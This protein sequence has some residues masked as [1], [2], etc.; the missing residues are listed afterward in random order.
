MPPPS[1]TST[2]RNHG[3][4]ALWVPRFF[5]SGLFQGD[6]QLYK[7]LNGGNESVIGLGAAGNFVRL[8]QQALHQLGYGRFLKSGIDGKFGDQT[9]KAVEQFQQDNQLVIDGIVGSETLGKLDSLVVGR[10]RPIVASLQDSNAAMDDEEGPG[11][12]LIL[13]T[14]WRHGST[15]SGLTKVS[16]DVALAILDNMAKSKEQISFLPEKGAVG[17]CSWFTIEGDPYVGRLEGRTIELSV[18]IDISKNALIFKEADIIERIKAKARSFDAEAA[19]RARH[20][21]PKEQVLTKKQSG[22]IQKLQRELPER[23]V[24]NEIGEAI[25]RHS[26]K[27]GIIEYDGVDRGE[28]SLSKGKPGK[29]IAIADPKQI[30]IKG[31]VGSVIEALQAQGHEV[32]PT[33]KEASKELIRRRNASAKVKAVFKYGGRVLIVVG[34]A[35][36]LYRIYRAENK[37][38]E[39]VKVAGGWVGAGLFASAFAAWWTPADVAGP[40]AWAI[41]GVG[42]LVAGGVGYFVGSESVAYVYEL[43]LEE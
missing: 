7:T 1:R 15:A 35:A 34:A 3:A 20:G 33:L 2:R 22:L 6:P 14:L 12:P 32:D 13:G 26:S 25:R 39:T 40:V 21:I 42:T 29:T 9:R 28:W 5:H 37:L 31:G 41:H 17:Q 30:T 4:A 18:S 11:R 24:W 36:D 43:V 10:Q 8:I 23:Q 19:Y 16:P 27:M 38:K